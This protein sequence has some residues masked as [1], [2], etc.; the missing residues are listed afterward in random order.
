[1]D[2]HHLPALI[3]KG[4]WYARTGDNRAANS[5]FQAAIKLAKNAPSLPTEWSKEIQRIEQASQRIALA[6]EAHLRTALNGHGLDSPGSERFAH[7]LDL[8]LGKRETYYQQP[9][10][11][12]F[13]ELPHVQFYDRQ[14]FPWTAAVEQASA[15]IRAELMSAM[16]DG[17]GFAPYVQAETN[18]HSF[19]PHGM[20][21]N[22]NWS[23]LFLIKDG[24][25]VPENAMRCPRTMAAMREVPLCRINGRT[26]SVLF[27]LLRPGTRIP[28]HHGFMNT[29]L[30]CHLPLIV[31]PNC[32]LR[33]G[34]ETR[35]WTQGQLLMFDDSIEH[36][37]WNSSDEL[38]VV[39][40][41]DVWRPELSEKE[42]ALVT[43][44][45]ESINSF[46]GP[47][48]EWVE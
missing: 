18:R 8:L 39:L 37:A 17:A 16:K 19:N 14:M 1:M 27:S 11:F 15:E 43:A 28:P 2:A 3:G 13:P 6:Y 48:R 12:F 5:Y 33:V 38:R 4:D 10:H 9:K 40:I 23:A 47:R 7:A 29:R 21:D 35:E 25:E 30:I 34:N 26:P 32:G 44:T 20:Q 41:F 45:L 46:G 24:T 42:Q 31:P 36:E 22:P